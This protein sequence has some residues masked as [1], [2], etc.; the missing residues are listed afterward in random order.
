M[1]LRLLVFSALLAILQGCGTALPQRQ[2]VEAGIFLQPPAQ[3]RATAIPSGKNVFVG[4]L[5]SS[6]AAEGIRYMQRRYDV[7]HD[8]NIL[9]RGDYVAANR[10]VR[11]PDFVI[12]WLMKSL[13]ERFGQVRVFDDMAALNNMQPD[14][15]A[16]LDLQVQLPDWG[17]P[18]TLFQSMI[19]FYDSHGE[20]IAE[21]TGSATKTTISGMY[22]EAQIIALTYADKLTII[23]ALA[24]LDESIDGITVRP[25]LAQN[26]ASEAYDQCMRGAIRVADGQLRTQAMAACNTAQ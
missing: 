4:V 24:A 10:N 15:I 23:E 17:Q 18:T 16:L 25:V 7:A 12:K 14:L 20:F 3:S 21:A 22:S 6:N 9:M 2:P 8:G 5:L 26:T 19:R 11:D 1:K 13:G